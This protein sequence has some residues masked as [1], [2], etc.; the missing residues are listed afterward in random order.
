MNNANASYFGSIL[1][2]LCGKLL[3]ELSMSVYIALIHVRLS[4]NSESNTTKQTIENKPKQPG[5]LFG[6]S[7]LIEN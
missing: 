2:A 7:G 1:V 6:V 4:N 3:S 5:P